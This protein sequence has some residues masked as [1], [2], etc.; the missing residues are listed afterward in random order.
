VLPTGHQFAPFQQGADRTVDSDADANGLSPLVQVQA[1]KANRDIDAGMIKLGSVGDF[2]WRDLN[3][4]GIQD[5]DEPG[6]PGIVV[7]LLGAQGSAVGD[8]LTGRDGKYQFDG[9]EPAKKYQVQFVLPTGYA[10]APF[11]QGND[12]TVDSDAGP[13]GKS[14]FFQVAR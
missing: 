3:G 12:P 13:G 10:F 11:Q 9:L 5:P 4:N 6:V 14:P 7:R 1:G 8:T 2:V